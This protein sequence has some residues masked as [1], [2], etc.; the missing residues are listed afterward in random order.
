MDGMWGVS[1]VTTPRGAF[2]KGSAAVLPP[3]KCSCLFV[4]PSHHKGVAVTVQVGQEF[5]CVEPCRS[6]SFPKL[7]Q[8]G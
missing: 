6:Q 4:A 1:R 2:C 7:H 8:Q 5:G 3:S